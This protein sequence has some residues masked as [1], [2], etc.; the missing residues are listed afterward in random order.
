MAEGEGT[1]NRGRLGGFLRPSSLLLFLAMACRG[2]TEVGADV[3]ADTEQ[4]DLGAIDPSVAEDQGAEVTFANAGLTP[5]AVVTMSVEGPDADRVVADVTQLPDQL[6]PGE[7]I[8]L[9]LALDARVVGSP[10]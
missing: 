9:G 1:V 8:T 2:S 5:V 4:I 6:A 3:L 10:M 7:L